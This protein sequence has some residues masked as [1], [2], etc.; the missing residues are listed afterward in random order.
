MKQPAPILDH[1]APGRKPART[2]NV[3]L[4]EDSATQALY[5]SGV[6]RSRAGWSVHHARTAAEAMRM[7]ESRKPDMVLI[8]YYLPKTR[9]DQLCRQMRMRVDLR[10][11]PIVILTGDSGQ[12]L[13]LRGLE[14]GADDF[15]AKSTDEDVLLLKLTSLLT[16][17]MERPGGSDD[18]L[19]FRGARILAVDDSPTYLTY[20]TAQLASLGMQVVTAA[21]G[22]EAI[23]QVENGEIDCALVDLMMPEID[24][25]E[26][27]RRIA[28]MRREGRKT[29][30]ALML[31]ANEDNQSL[32]RALEAGADDFVGKSCDSIV[33]KGRI[34][35]LLRRKFLEDEHR[36]R[37]SAEMR[38][39]ELEAQQAQMQKEA[40]EARAALVDD[41]QR[42]AEALR[43]SNEELQ[44]F[45]YVASHD[46]Q[47][48]LRMVASYVQLIERRLG[49]NI[50]DE[51]REFVGFVVSGVGRMKSLIRDLLALS[52][53]DSRGRELAQVD[54]QDVLRDALANLRTAIVEAAGMVTHDPLP[55]VRGDRSQLVQL[56]Q[57]LIGNAIKYRSEAPPRV[58]VSAV[59]QG[60]TCT[61]SVRD[62][63]IGID[64]QFFERVFVIFQ[65]LHPAHEYPGTGI[66]LAIARKIV[67]RHGGRI[68]IESRPGEGATFLFTLPVA[69]QVESAWQRTPGE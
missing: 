13:E 66:G 27:C 19:D 26:V 28:A 42:T 60:D 48:P 25:I 38:S 63:G 41:L 45:A 44:R 37:L 4:V 8:D 46:L 12:E 69:R 58:H 67:E 47:E 6:L 55:A 64:P 3:L 57:N 53:V 36:R 23:Q 17:A 9:G 29:P 51:M 14:S 39:L 43:R 52:R 30:M 7:L 20:L 50:D 11:T 35:A 33:I 22:A 1:D 31:T 65:R 24:G 16:R 10:T 15:L 18:D 49:Q 5:L 32:T 40:A 21:S 2:P 54:L 59:T 62:N 68:W 34:R 61:V 56:L